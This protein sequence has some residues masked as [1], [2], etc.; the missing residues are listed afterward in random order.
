MFIGEEMNEKQ[1]EKLIEQL[2]RGDALHRSARAVIV[3]LISVEQDLMSPDVDVKAIKKT[4]K[5]VNADEKV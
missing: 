2:S 1:I 5:K 4:T 3:D